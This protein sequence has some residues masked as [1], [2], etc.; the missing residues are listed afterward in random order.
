[1]KTS[2][3]DYNL[4]VEL[5]AQTPLETRDRSR[6]MVLNCSE[7]SIEHRHF[8]QID[9]F[10]NSGDILILNNSRVIPARLLGIKEENGKKIELLLL[11]RLE[12]GIWETLAKPAKHIKLGTII[13]ITG[14][15]NWKL[16]VSSTQ[17]EV[18]GEGDGGLRT[19]RFSNETMLEDMGETPLPP[20][21]NAKLDNPERYQTV[22][23]S[24]KGSVAAP[25]A[26]LHFT[27]KLLDR[28]T[29]KEVEIVFVTLHVGL[30]SFRP[31]RVDDP[32]QHPIHKEHGEISKEAA[33]KI[34]LAR[35]E[36]RRIVCV[37]TTAARLL[38]HVALMEGELGGLKP[39]D[40]WVDLMIL[41]GHEFKILDA[42]VT[43]FHLPRST[44]L[45]LV[46]AFAGKNII[47]LA[48][49]K[50]IREKYRF[51][52]FGDAMIILP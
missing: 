14:N 35:K 25:T 23:A 6:L 46:S 33:D 34:T 26:G 13:Y 47:D 1:M 10:I 7:G 8:Y 5:I 40:G 27:P 3:F 20:Y 18:I 50:A 31:I 15:L 28:L 16:D 38:E 30:D 32:R 37:G 44:L 21:I 24:K 48:Y 19:V 4:P 52:S 17:V 39:F 42:L 11:R 9:E 49:Q 43:N 41:P 22:Y 36:G 29:G 2:E 12:E 51:Y 45:M